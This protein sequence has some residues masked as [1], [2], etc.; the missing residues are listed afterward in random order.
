MIQLQTIN[1]RRGEQEILHNSDLT[2]HPGWH[3]AVVGNNGC[4]KSSLFALLTEQ[5]EIDSG[6][7]EIPEAWTIAHMEQEVTNLSRSAIDYVIDGD[8]FLRETQ[9]EV[10]K[11]ENSN[12]KNTLNK[13]DA[14]KL[15]HLYHELEILDAYTAEARAGKMLFGLGFS[16][17]DF[18]R[19][20]S[21]FSGGWRMRLNL[22]HTLMCPSDLLLLDEPTNHLDLDALLWLEKWLKNY[23]GTLILIS[24]DREFLD[25]TVNH[26]VHIELKSLNYYRGNYSEF[27]KQRASRLAQQQSAFVKQQREIEHIQKFITRFKAKATKARQA[28]SRIKALEKLERVAPAHIDSPFSFHFSNPDKLPDPLLKISNAT[29]G[30]KNT[31]VIEAVNLSLSPGSRIGI[32]GPNGAGK[33]TFIKSLAKQLPLLEGEFQGSQHLKLGYFAQHQLEHLDLNA[34]ALLQLQRF[35]KDENE[36]SLRTYLGSFDFHGDKVTERI[37]NFSGGEKARLALALIIWQKPNL[38]LLDEPTNHLDIEMR[39]ALALALQDFNGAVIL[40]SHDR[41]LIRCTTEELYL[42]ANNKLDIFTGSLD[43]YEKWLVDCRDSQNSVN[44]KTISSGVEGNKPN[45]KEERKKNAEQRKKLRPITAKIKKIES[46]MDRISTHQADLNTQLED[47]RLYEDENKIELKNLLK[48]Q[49][50]LN[51]NYSRYEEEWM[52]LNEELEKIESELND[53]SKG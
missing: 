7:F 11:L 5:L 47:T 43:D 29:L 17:E 32:L 39:H 2:I 23:T 52:L 8:S 36:T 51:Q 46:E 38:L 33:S 18:D 12:Q 19:S 20:V 3:V 16:A 50:E 41:H 37:T 31:P 24:H 28:Q 1:L 10:S 13:N 21:E 34:S 15:A 53:L 48:T 26:I 30:Y 25:S 40:V 27:E 4:G 14:E 35:A 44:N 9:R 49:A 42:I 45:R 6:R 22:A